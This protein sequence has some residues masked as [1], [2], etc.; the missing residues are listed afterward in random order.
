MSSTVCSISSS[1]LVVAAETR[2]CF[3]TLVRLRERIN[4]VVDPKLVELSMGMTGDF[5]AAVEEGATIVR[6]GRVLTGER[7]G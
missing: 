7:T 2:S 4:Q 3:R 5:E 1:R 6:L